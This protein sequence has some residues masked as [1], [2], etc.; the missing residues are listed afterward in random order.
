VLSAA[1]IETTR[2][3]LTPLVAAD[4]DAMVAV[5]ADE[6]MHAFTGGHPL[7]LEE[8]RPRYE[9]LESG[10]SP[11]GTEAWLN[12]IVRI[13]HDRRPI[14]TMQATVAPEGTSADAAWEIGVADQG[15]GFGSEA[16]SAVVEWLLRHGV[17]TVRAYIHPQHA[18][19][20]AVAAR[21]GLRATDEVVDGE[22]VWL[23]TAS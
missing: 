5:L 17:A 1:T 11:D 2:L 18:A 4:A 12:W 6:R 13:A 15:S 21:A 9:R 7:S 23:R 19:S 8:L 20:A 16:A 3:V 22:T 14:G 10:R